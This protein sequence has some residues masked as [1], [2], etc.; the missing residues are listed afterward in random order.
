MNIASILVHRVT[1]VITGVK[2]IEIAANAGVRAQPTAQAVGEMTEPQQAPKGRKSYLRLTFPCAPFKPEG[3]QS[4][5]R[6]AKKLPGNTVEER[7]F[8]AASGAQKSGALALRTSERELAARVF[9][10]QRITARYS[11]NIDQGI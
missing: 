6:K 4:E 8:S 10:S 7:R 2:A 3:S 9:L 5:T 1:T 11:R